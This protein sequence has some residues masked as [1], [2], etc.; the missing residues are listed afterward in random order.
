MSELEKAFLKAQKSMEH[1][2]KDATNP[3]FK[4]KYASYDSLVAAVKKPL[5]DAGLSFRHTS[6]WA[7]SLYFVGSYLIY[8]ETGE[9]TE[10][11]DVP[12]RV[13]NAQ[14]TGSALSYARRYS[15]GA[16]CGIAA[17]EDDDGNAASG[18][19]SQKSTG[20]VGAIMPDTYTAAT[21]QK[22]PFA[23]L[24]L[25]LGAADDSEVLKEIS[26]Y[27][28]GTPIKDLRKKIQEFLTGETK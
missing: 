5:N 4:S 2:S 6:R 8:G 9:K 19:S 28:K 7:D 26:N 10:V 24:A 20:N 17:A 27:C 1:V 11:F 16:L 3:F 18:N 14:E 15:L 22:K 12:V 21:D 23:S 25:E 13:G